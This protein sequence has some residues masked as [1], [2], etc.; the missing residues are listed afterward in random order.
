MKTCFFTWITKNFKN[1]IVDFDGFL[2]SYKKYYH[3]IDLIIFEDESLKNIYKDNPWIYSDNCKATLAKKLY[4]Q[5]DLVICVDSDFYFFGRSEEILLGD[6]DLGA[7]ANYN[8]WLNTKL[9]KQQIEGVDIPEVSYEKYFQAGLIASTNKNFW[10]EY[11]YY[12]KLLA[13]KLPTRDNDVLNYII[14]SK[15]YKTKVFD[16]DLDYRSPNFKKFFNCSS[17]G[18]E[19]NIILKNNQ[20]YLFDKQVISY[21]VARGNNGPNGVKKLRPNELFNKEV[22]DWFYSDI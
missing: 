1:S 20:L 6:Y 4:N 8:C 3:D 18:N 19:Q 9:N 17:L 22:C 14:Y 7:C 21:H 16:G 5:Y 15:N 13:R 10:D 12:S 11:E 2:K